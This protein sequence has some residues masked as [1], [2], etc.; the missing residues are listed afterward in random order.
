[1]HSIVTWQLG[2]VITHWLERERDR[3]IVGLVHS[4]CDDGQCDGVLQEGGEGIERE[5]GG[6][7]AAGVK[8]QRTQHSLHQ[9]LSGGL[10]WEQENNLNRCIMDPYNVR[11]KCTYLLYIPRMEKSS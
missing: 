1:M 11:R 10:V 4:L 9:A 2:P 5:E 3:V 7:T 6:V 8:V